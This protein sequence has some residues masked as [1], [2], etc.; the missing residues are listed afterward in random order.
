MG[1]FDSNGNS[2]T[3]N[4][5]NSSGIGNIFGDTSGDTS[6]HNGTG[7]HD[8]SGNIFG[9][10]S[11]GL[12]GMF[13]DASGGM[14]GG[15]DASGTDA[16]GINL[17]GMAYGLAQMVGIALVAGIAVALVFVSSQNLVYLTSKEHLASIPINPKAPPYAPG[18]PPGKAHTFMNRILYEYGPPYSFK[19]HPA[20]LPFIPC[21]YKSLRNLFGI[22]RWIGETS[23]NAWIH[24]RKLLKVVLEGLAGL[25]KWIKMPFAAIFMILMILPIPLIGFVFTFS[26]SFHANIGWSILGILT[27]ILPAMASIISSAQGL[28]L[29]WYLFISPIMTPEGRAFIF[30]QVQEH[31]KPLRLIY[32]ALIILLSPLFL[33]PMYTLGMIIGV[34]LFGY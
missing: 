20:V 32:T 26:A 34:I 12:G 28:I 17:K 2:S 11:G 3:N 27:A 7:T 1:L 15:L 9:N 22:K 10:A 33:P 6:K 5:N 23:I 25:P 19:D 8:G 30:K 14:F 29:S 21:N 24:S 13:G 4:T 16:S 18:M 31:K